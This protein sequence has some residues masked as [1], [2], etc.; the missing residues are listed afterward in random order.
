MTYRHRTPVLCTVFV[1]SAWACAAPAG[2]VYRWVDGQG[3]V[4]YSDQRGAADAEPVPLQSAP[5]PDASAAARRAKGLKLLQVLEEEREERRARKA[6]ARRTREERRRKCAQARR[7][8]SSYEHAR[9]IYDEDGK[10]NRRILSDAEHREVLERA[11]EAVQ[12]LCASP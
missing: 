5:P 10:G 2:T 12:R 3:G 7:Q 6:K 8:Q 4:H 11:A 9:Y 1:L